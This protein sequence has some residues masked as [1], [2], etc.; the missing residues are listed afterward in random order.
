MG[1]VCC[2][3]YTPA[4]PPLS[5]E[6]KAERRAAAAA[7]AED[8][9]QRFAQGGVD[10][11]KRNLAKKKDEARAATAAVG[12]DGKPDLTDARVWD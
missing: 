12:N 3:L 2:G 7:A 11:K 6:E 4:P 5:E 10:A 8:R 1:A 9:G